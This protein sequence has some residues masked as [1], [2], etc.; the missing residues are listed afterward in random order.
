MAEIAGC[1]SCG[2]CFDFILEKRC[3]ANAIVITGKNYKCASIDQN[4]CV[5]CGLCLKEIECLG[6]A[7]K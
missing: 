4:L 3:P 6:D 7:L 1:S 5:G 2:N